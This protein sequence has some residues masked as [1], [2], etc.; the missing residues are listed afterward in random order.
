MLE[1]YL[2][3][4]DVTSRVRCQQL[5]FGH[6]EGPES[7]FGLGAFRVGRVQPPMMTTSAAY[8]TNGVSRWTPGT[9]LFTILTVYAPIV[10]GVA[11]DPDIVG[12]EC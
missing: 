6:G 2:I 11:G 12:I 3:D 10:F 8:R 9:V 5:V 7:R 4:G 1:I